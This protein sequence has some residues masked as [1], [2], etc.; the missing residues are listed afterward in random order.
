M[1]LSKKAAGIVLNNRIGPFN[2]AAAGEDLSSILDEIDKVIVTQETIADLSGSASTHFLFV[3]DRA[4]T[5][6]E[7]YAVYVEASSADAGIKLNIGK[8]IVGTDDPDYFVDDVDTLASKETGYR[9][10][11]TL[12]NTTVAEGDVI[13]FTNAGGKVGTGNVIISMVLKRA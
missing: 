8:M 1:A 4:Y 13:Y 12:T 5:I 9:Q 3:A 7:C 11:L 6:E 2:G 10:S